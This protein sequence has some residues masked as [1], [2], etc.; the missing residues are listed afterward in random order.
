MFKNLFKIEKLKITAYN[1]RERNIEDNTFEAM[2]NPESYS[3]RYET[4]FQEIQGLNTSG[5][6]AKYSLSKPNKLSLKIILDD[7][8]VTDFGAVMLPGLCK[9]KDVYKQVRKFLK[10]TYTM[11]GQIHEPRYLKIEWGDLVFSC[12]L[13]S[14]DVKYTMFDRTGKPI[15]AELDTSFIGDIEDS[16]RIKKEQ[17]ESPDLTHVRTIKSDDTI[18]MMTKRIYGNQSLYIQVALANGLN[19]FRK[20]KPGSSLN[21][22]PIKK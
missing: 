10:L 14:V 17:K 12:R 11:D 18:P 1:D 2:F 19:N 20:L 8:G 15:R 3:L 13:E 6:E 16:E 7:S 4:V 5:R 9:D 21:F 22:P